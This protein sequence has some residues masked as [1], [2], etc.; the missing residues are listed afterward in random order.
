MYQSTDDGEQ[1]T[2]VSQCI[3]FSGFYHLSSVICLLSSE[4]NN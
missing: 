1:K 2:E 4:T 3:S